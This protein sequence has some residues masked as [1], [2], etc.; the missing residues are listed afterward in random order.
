LIPAGL[1]SARRRFREYGKPMQQA[2]EQSDW[3]AQDRLS[4]VIDKPFALGIKKPLPLRQTRTA[5]A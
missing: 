5:A 4:G 1:L 2:Q 3:A